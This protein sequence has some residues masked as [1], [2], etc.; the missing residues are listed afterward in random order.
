MDFLNRLLREDI[1]RSIA[2]LDAPFRSVVVMV[3]QQGMSY[4]EVART[5]DIPLGTVRSRLA[6]ARG[7]L[8]EKLWE[9]AVDAGL[10]QEPT[11]PHTDEP[12]GPPDTENPSGERAP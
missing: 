9:H 8:Q 3:D 6:R 11:P 10:R 4:R 1:D 5:L 12:S 7:R 2:E